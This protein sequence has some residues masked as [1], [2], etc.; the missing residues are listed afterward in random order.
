MNKKL[1]PDCVLQIMCKIC[2]KV[3]TEDEDWDFDKDMCVECVRKEAE[4]LEKE[5]DVC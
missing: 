5:R 1:C 3:I 4:K 2:K